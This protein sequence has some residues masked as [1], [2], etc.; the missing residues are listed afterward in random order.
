MVEVVVKVV[1]DVIVEV[2]IQ[3][4]KSDPEHQMIS[5]VAHLR[6]SL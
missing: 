4:H 5:S 2:K 6:R 3:L 1:V